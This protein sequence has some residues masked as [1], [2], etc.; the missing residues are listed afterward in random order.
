[1]VT[2]VPS[3]AET[4][5]GPTADTLRPTTTRES[6][7]TR[8]VAENGATPRLGLSS[9]TPLSQLKVTRSFCTRTGSRTTSRLL[10]PWNSTRTGT[11]TDPSISIE[12]PRSSVYGARAVTTVTVPEPTEATAARPRLGAVSY[13]SVT[14]SPS[15]G[16]LGSPTEP[17]TPRGGRFHGTGVQ[18]GRRGRARHDG[19]RHR[20]GAGPQR[21]VRGGRGQGRR[22]PGPRP[23]PRRRLDQAGRRPGQDVA[24]GAA[25]A[26]G[27]DL[28]GHRT[29]CDGRGRPGHR[30][31]PR[32]ARAQARDLH[33]ARRHLQARHDPGQQHVVALDHRDRSLHRPPRQG[34]RDALLQPGPGHEARRGHPHRG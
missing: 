15:A 24:G 14:S 8:M 34:C 3:T 17:L 19:G 25:V 6:C 26:A 27:P 4:R 1:M 33:R 22:R 29:R 28:L 10:D 21:A 13:F 5:T 30:G 9:T 2:V 12:L 23:R 31:R 18:A 11:S 7:P 16:G 20:R 32:E